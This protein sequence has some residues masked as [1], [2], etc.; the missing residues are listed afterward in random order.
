MM[1]MEPVSSQQPNNGIN[2]DDDYRK[3]ILQSMCEFYVVFVVIINL[4]KR[5]GQ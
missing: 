4:N 5:N 3:R 2:R 1:A